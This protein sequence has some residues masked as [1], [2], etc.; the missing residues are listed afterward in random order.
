VCVC[1]HVCLLVYWLVLQPEASKGNRKRS[2]KWVNDKCLLIYA[3]ENICWYR[4]LKEPKIVT[5]ASLW[6]S[7]VLFFFSIYLRN[8]LLHIHGYVNNTTCIRIQY[9]HWKWIENHCV[10]LRIGSSGPL[11]PISATVSPSTNPSHPTS[12]RSG[13]RVCCTWDFGARHELYITFQLPG[14]QQSASPVH[15]SVYLH[16]WLYRLQLAV[17]PQ[18][19]AQGFWICR[20]MAKRIVW[21]CILHILVLNASFVPLLLVRFMW[22]VAAYEFGCRTN[23]ACYFSAF[24]S[25]G[26]F[27]RGCFCFCTSFDSSRAF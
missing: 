4:Q 9:F 18:A 15:F 7:P 27:S 26:D 22:G 16:V 3:G 20:T 12:Q 23:A 1:V 8:F 19:H 11:R 10:L 2:T 21:T 13:N 14:E 24:A 6:V 5:C 25:G 17:T